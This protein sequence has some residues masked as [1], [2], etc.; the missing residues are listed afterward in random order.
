MK[1]GTSCDEAEIFVVLKKIDVT[2]K[3]SIFFI[4]ITKQY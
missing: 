3:D 1:I 4:K 2:M